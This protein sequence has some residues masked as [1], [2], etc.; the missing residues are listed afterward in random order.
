MLLSFLLWQQQ[1]VLNNILN[2]KSVHVE[3]INPKDT[4]YLKSSLGICDI[5]VIAT[6]LE[7][8]TYA[9]LYQ[10]FWLSLPNSL[11][12][13]NNQLL[14]LLPR[15]HLLHFIYFYFVM[16]HLNNYKWLTVGYWRTNEALLFAETWHHT[17]SLC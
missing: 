6:I 12:L 1:A 3:I 15:S 13:W 4:V 5:Q 8:F 17:Q 14:Q 2:V 16:S 10:I 7:G 9:R 11:H